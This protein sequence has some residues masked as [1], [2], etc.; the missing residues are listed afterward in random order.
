MRVD[1]QWLLQTAAQRGVLLS[2]ILLLGACAG[3]SPY[4]IN[5]MP[6]PEVYEVDVIDPFADATPLDDLPYDGMLYATDRAPA[7]QGAREDYYLNQRGQVVRL[8]VAQVELARADITWEE[9][10]RISLLKNR[11][12]KFPIRVSGVEEYGVLDRSATVFE[13]PDTLG[14]DPH[15]AA[16]S[17]AAAVNAKLAQSK[18]KHIYVYVHGYK[19]VFENPVLVATELWHFLGYDGVFVAYS[20]PSTPSRWA[21]T[22]D[23]ET[24]EGSARNL[25]IFLEYLADE[26]EAEQIHVVGYSAGTRLVAR[27][28]EQMALMNHERTPAAIYARQRIGHVILVGADVDRQVFGAYIADGLLTV[29][30]HVGVYMSEEDK[31]LR[32][33]RFLTRQE[34]L[35]Q[36][37]AA[38]ELG[39][40]AAD[41]LHESAGDISVINVTSA[42]G[43]TG[44]NGHAYFRKSPW[45][46]SDILMTLAYDLP[47]AER[48][49]VRETA[50]PVWT[51]PPDYIERL[52]AALMKA[53]PKV[54]RGMG[55]RGT[56]LEDSARH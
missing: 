28:F 25:R 34:R 1:Y 26:T 43:S 45:A 24:A 31:A 50:A 6:A 41:F 7:Q 46:S 17:F 40:Q 10:R 55:E 22:R 5:L 19:V 37:W 3:A 32:V 49:L 52:R 15:A 13:E 39:P 9:A 11:T 35:G 14:E 30:Q 21:Y 23:T 54:A 38:E 8:G 4:E 12:D 20:W 51:F 42:E 44:G 27:A 56:V 33:A 2:L 48:G 36:M 53:N 16:A 47:P 18:R 29:P